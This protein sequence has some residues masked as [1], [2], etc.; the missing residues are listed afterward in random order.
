[1]S[2]ACDPG[3]AGLSPAPAGKDAGARGGDMSSRASGW[4]CPQ[5]PTTISTRWRLTSCTT[6]HGRRRRTG[7]GGGPGV[8]QDPGS[9]CGPKAVTYL[10]IDILL[11]ARV[12]NN[13]NNTNRRL[14]PV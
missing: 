2:G 1:M 10:G 11:N 4:P 13:N 8:L 6:A 7:Q 12:R 9:T 5:P 3:G 14:T